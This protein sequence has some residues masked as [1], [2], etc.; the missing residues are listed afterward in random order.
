V[1]RTRVG[2]AGG[3][4][5]NPTYYNIGD[6]SETVQVDFD[7]SRISYDTLVDA[8]WSGH[9]PTYPSYSRQYRSV[10]LYAS[11]EQRQTAIKSKQREESRLGKVLF[12][13]IEA[14]NGFYVAENYHQKYYLRETPDL[15]AEISSIYP[16]PL[17]LMNSTAAAR[18][19]GYIAG[20]GNQD[21]LKKQLNNLG[22]SE[23]S[24]QRLLQITASG[25]IPGCPINP[26]GE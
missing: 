5:G 19:N 3:T 17:D 12:T 6:H 8:F 4:T 11:E 13:D 20:Y 22:L 18:L 7:P 2:Y 14:D 10:I 23:A 1:V 9:N 26:S 21:T 24:Q 16:H 25:L 15:M